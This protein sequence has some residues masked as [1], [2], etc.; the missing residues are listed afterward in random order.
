MVDIFPYLPF[1]IRRRRINKDAGKIIF[2]GR[3]PRG[4]NS[5][6]EFAITT[7]G[8]GW[9]LNSPFDEVDRR[10]GGQC[11][12]NMRVH[13]SRPISQVSISIIDLFEC[14]MPNPSSFTRET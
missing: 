10:T 4:E 5:G 7:H 1:N 11:R 9:F 3:K 14:R 6:R 13:A 2:P 8:F 12:R